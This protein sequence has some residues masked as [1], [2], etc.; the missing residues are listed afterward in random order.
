[1]NHYDEILKAYADNGFRS[2]A[3]W[4]TLGRAVE[5]GAAPRAE[6]THQR[7]TVPLYSRDQTRRRERGE[8][9]A[10]RTGPAAAAPPIQG[11]TTT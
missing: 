6:A 4:L 5:T 8:G 7:T 10:Q 2:A 11:A 3:E 9:R 1:M